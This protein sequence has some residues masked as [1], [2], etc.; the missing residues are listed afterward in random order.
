LTHYRLLSQIE[1]PAARDFYG[2]ESTRA[3]WS[4]RELERQIHSLLFER[5]LKTKDKRGALKRLDSAQSEKFEPKDLIKDPY[6]LEFTGLPESGDFLESD[7]EKA[8]V[9]KLQHFLL[10]LGKGFAFIGRQQRLLRQTC[11]HLHSMKQDASALSRLGWSSQFAFHYTWLLR[12]YF[13][14][15]NSTPT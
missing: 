4:T 12:V 8:L 6:V 7:L 10:E 5:L 9:A 15:K 14:P 1:K 2:K 3:G 11:G 13:S